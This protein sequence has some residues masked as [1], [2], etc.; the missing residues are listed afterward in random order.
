M[1]SSPLGVIYIFQTQNQTPQH[2]SSLLSTSIV[3][4]LLDFSPSGYHQQ[5]SPWHVKSCNPT[6]NGGFILQIYGFWSSCCELSWC[7][8]RMFPICC[9]WQNHRRLYAFTHRRFCHQSWRER[10]QRLVPHTED[11]Y[12][13][14]WRHRLLL[15][16]TAS[17]C[18]P[19]KCSEKE[20]H[21]ML[22]LLCQ[23]TNT[24]IDYYFTIYFTT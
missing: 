19:L 7:W 6:S 22:Y 8:V 14:E 16:Q 20:G 24:N 1:T 2:T 17:L 13:P 23:H 9:M 15:S 3:Q 4:P 10:W 11:T 21:V 5:I 12:S 18:S